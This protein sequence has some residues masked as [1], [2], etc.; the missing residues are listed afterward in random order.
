MKGLK[1]AVFTAFSIFLMYRSYELVSVL[2]KRDLTQLGVGQ[3]VFFAILL[4]VFIT[5]VFAFP[6][7]VFP[8]NKLL[9]N[10]FY[11]IKHPVA[12]TQLYALLKVDWFRKGLL[13]VFWG[14]KGNRKRYFNGSRN[15]IQNFIYQ[16]KQSEFGH[17][18]PFIA[19]SLVSGALLA[20]GQPVLVVVAMFIN[21]V[22]NFYPIIL[23]RHHRM[24]ITR[25]FDKPSIN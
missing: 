11:L 1:K 4:N 12:L 8:T 6:G 2:L 19:I 5:G 9:P 7:F 24:R 16:S 18:G 3:E 15:G 10:G 14:K 17:L 13:L 25:I 23:Q 20:K 21:T 22:G